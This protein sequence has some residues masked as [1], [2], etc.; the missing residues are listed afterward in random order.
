MMPLPPA[1]REQIVA[2]LAA[3]EIELFIG[4]E[5]GP[6]PLRAAPAFA[7]TPEEV[8][9]LIWDATCA[10]NLAAFLPRYRGRRI[11]LLVK[12]CDARAVVG[13]E[14]E[15]QVVRENLRLVGAPCPGVVDP[16]R[17][18]ARLGL[19]TD[20]LEDVAVEGEWVVAPGGTR[21]PLDE[22]RYAACAACAQC[23]PADAD[24]LVGPPL[25]ESDQDAD[26]DPFAAVRAM[27]ALDTD[28]RWA[29][30]SQAVADCTLCYAC[31]NACPLCY[32]AVCFADR[33]QPR[34]FTPTA[35]AADAQFF[36]IMRTF[37]LAGR[38]VG[39]GACTRACPQGIDLRLL[40]DKL[41]LDVQELYGYEAGLDPTARPPLT[42]YRSD[43]PDDFT[44]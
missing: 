43:D 27:E 19:A 29:R 17:V 32:C 33:T 10:P 4:Y 18:A 38:C 28:A 44:L 13:L 34:W 12:G 36:Q 16:R 23:T 40:Q 5:L 24:L 3:G 22:V 14:Q 30:F 21:L 7:R 31:R 26:A 42:T 41:R 25:T 39:C 8:E 9:R 20:E 37:H 6:L 1:V 15:G 11:G 35:Q 2:W